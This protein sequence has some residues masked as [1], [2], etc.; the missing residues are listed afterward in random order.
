MI[1]YKN[2]LIL[3]TSKDIVIKHFI[4]NDNYILLFEWKKKWDYQII[5][6]SRNPDFYFNLVELVSHP[7]Q[8]IELFLTPHPITC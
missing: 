2:S 1:T 6:N 7:L 8:D 4:L 3:I 5:D